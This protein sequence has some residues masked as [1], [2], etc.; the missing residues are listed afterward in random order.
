MKDLRQNVLRNLMRY[1]TF[2]FCTCNNISSVDI[3]FRQDPKVHHTFEDC[4]CPLL[5]VFIPREYHLHNLISYPLCL[6]SSKWK[7]RNLTL[8]SSMI[9]WIINPIQD[10]PF[11][12]CSRIGGQQGPPLSKICHI[13]PT[14]M[15]L[16]MDI[17]TLPK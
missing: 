11:Q 5:A 2:I 13:Y 10:W 4:V 3:M 12:G 16:G 17:Y 1:L 8:L 14:L 9:Y 15:K 7:S 6:T